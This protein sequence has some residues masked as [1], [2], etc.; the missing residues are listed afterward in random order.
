MTVYK[1]LQQTP[2]KLL[3]NLLRGYHGFRTEVIKGPF[4]RA[5]YKLLAT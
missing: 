1:S 5:R 2:E 4:E 3:D